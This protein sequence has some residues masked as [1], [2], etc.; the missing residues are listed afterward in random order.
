MRRRGRGTRADAGQST[1]ELALVLP[2][3]VALLLVVIQVG[4][5]VRDQILVV[6]A[7]R[8]AVR[9]ASVGDTDDQVRQVATRAGPLEA[10]RLTV[11]VRRQPGTPPTVGVHVTYR[12]PT[13]LPLVGG[14]VP[15]VD[16]EADA[17]MAQEG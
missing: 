6:H 15:D 2:L 4:L 8:E 7:A 3:V 16:L 14:L 9:A 13:D 10:D 5:V 12:C 11:L 17:V 1:V